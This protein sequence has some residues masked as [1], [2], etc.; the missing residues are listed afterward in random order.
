MADLLVHHVGHLVGRRP[1]PLADLRLARQPAGKADID[2]PILVGL[3]PGSALDVILAH[4]RAGFDRGVNLVAGAIQKSGIDE[5]DARFRRKNAG[6]E[7]DGRAPLLVHDAHFEGIAFER[8]N[9]FDARENLVR[10]RD[11]VRPVHFWF[12][13]VDRTCAAVAQIARVF[14]IV[15]RDERRHG[16]VENAF[17]NFGA[18]RIEHRVGVHVMPDIAHQ[19]ETAPG[20]PHLAGAWTFVDAI[21]M[22]IFHMDPGLG[23]HGLKTLNM[24]AHVPQPDRV[25]GG[26]PDTSN[27]DAFF[28]AN[29]FLQLLI[30]GQ[31]PLAALIED[32][33]RLRELQRPRKANKQ[34][35]AEPIFQL[36]HDLAHR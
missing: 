27:A 31:H 30:F 26:N 17:G 24:L 33:A 8:Q 2:V 35:D 9:I 1:H 19:H 4:D 7:I 15:D 18:A 36:R 23:M 29:R 5:H 13:D 10:Q 12:D 20:Q 16:G 3:D 25:D 21:G 11:F 22:E 6:F 14:E 28:A 34:F 32:L